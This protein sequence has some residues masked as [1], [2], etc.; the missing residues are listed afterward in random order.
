[1][2]LKKQSVET[3]RPIRTIRIGLVCVEVKKVW[4]GFAGSPATTNL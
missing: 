2:I 4:F 3:L 1:M